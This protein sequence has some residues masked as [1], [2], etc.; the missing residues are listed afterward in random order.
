MKIEFT[1]KGVPP[2]KDGASSM[3]GKGAE[4]PRLKELRKAARS[5]LGEQRPLSGPVRLT[6][7]VYAD[8]AVGDLD[9]FITG[10]CD[11][12]MA[13]HPGVFVDP[14]IWGDLPESARPR[15]AIA[16]D[17][18]SVVSSIHAE[19][20]VPDAESPRYDVELEWI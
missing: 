20:L 2:K 11:G 1:V 17:D 7:R 8:Q 3:W 5:A 19:R 13:A 4:V 15:V 14:V 6:L 10:V 9:N 16:F 18:D 12:L